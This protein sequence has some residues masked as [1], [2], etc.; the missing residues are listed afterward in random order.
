MLEIGHLQ[1]LFDN[2]TLLF[3]VVFLWDFNEDYVY[4]F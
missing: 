1:D 3:V 4:D 2:V